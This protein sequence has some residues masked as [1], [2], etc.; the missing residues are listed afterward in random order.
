MRR[1]LTMS[2][3]MLSLTA[4]AAWGQSQPESRGSSEQAAASQA[5]GQPG[6]S[7][8]PTAKPG[9][10]LLAEES[11]VEG[12]L[13][14]KIRWESQTVKGVPEEGQITEVYKRTA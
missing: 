14:I 13:A 3:T 8:G 10:G 1:N 12:N 9:G 7:T 11:G 2:L 4:L 5:E 6:P